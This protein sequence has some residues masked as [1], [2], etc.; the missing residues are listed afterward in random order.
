MFAHDALDT[1]WIAEVGRHGWVVVTRDQ[2][3]LAAVRAAG[4]RLF[5]LDSG[6]LSAAET[7]AIITRAWPAIRRA[8]IGTD[9][10]ALWSVMRAAG[11]RL[12]KQ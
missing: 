5:A 2:N 7:A 12:I 3:E 9:P 11:V 1:Q 10:P 6:K 4:L 8:V